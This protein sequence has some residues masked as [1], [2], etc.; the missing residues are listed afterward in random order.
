MRLPIPS[1]LRLKSKLESAVETFSFYELLSADESDT[2]IIAYGVTARAAKSVYRELKSAGKPVRL[3]ILKTLWPVPEKVL[4]DTAEPYSRILMVEMNLGQY[5]REVERF[6]GPKTV[7]F[8]GKMNGE[9]ISPEEITRVI[10][11]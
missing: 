3:L 7:E 1:L 11:P 6:S 9:L 4:K 2:L 5:V 10:A 8:F